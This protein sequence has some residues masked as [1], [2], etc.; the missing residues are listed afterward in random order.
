MESDT[1]ASLDQSPEVGGWGVELHA[2]KGSEF[3]Q[4]SGVFGLQT[5]H[6]W[7]SI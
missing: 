6:G 1:G 5:D 2:L 4:D 7:K 3:V